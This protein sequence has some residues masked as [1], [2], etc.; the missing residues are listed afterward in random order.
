MDE[1]NKVKN[2]YKAGDTIT[3]KI[4]RN[5]ED[6]DVTLTLQDANADKA[7]KKTGTESATEKGE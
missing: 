3:L 7:G 2:E 6:M 4:C 5:N 1:L